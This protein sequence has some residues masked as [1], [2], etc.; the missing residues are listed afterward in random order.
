M[1]TVKY[2]FWGIVFNQNMKWTDHIAIL[3]SKISKAIYIMRNPQYIFSENIFKMIYTSLV[4]SKLI[5]GLLL[6][7]VDLKDVADIQKKT[8]ET[9]N[10]CFYFKLY[11]SD[12]PAYF[13]RYENALNES[14]Q[15]Y[16]LRNNSIRVSI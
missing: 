7:G 16:N 3:I 4:E 5:Y 2:N 11:I 12:D 1:K 8:I 15:K 6:W 13:S 10:C 14:R 9:Q